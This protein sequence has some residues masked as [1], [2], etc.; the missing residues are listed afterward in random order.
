MTRKARNTKTQETLNK[1]LARY[2][3][4][5]QRLCEE[6]ANWGG[7]LPLRITY[8][9]TAETPPSVYVSSVRAIVFRGNEVLVVKQANG[10]VYILPGGR[11][12]AGEGKEQ[13]LR[14]E[15][16][17]ETGW[18]LKDMRLLG[19]MHLH[20]L[21]PKPAGYA[22]PYPDFIWPVYLAEAGD[23]LPQAV[24]PD[25]WVAESCFLPVSEARGLPLRAG[26]LMLLEAALRL[27]T[28]H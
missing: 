27:S 16:V 10:H 18:T 9:L 5:A 21:G 12:E 23:F 4:R 24:Q 7:N 26:E 22:Y 3:R 19:C 20:H 1:E 17:E 14:R 15:V 28:D 11:V 6:S 13:T 25:D 2:L 8:Y